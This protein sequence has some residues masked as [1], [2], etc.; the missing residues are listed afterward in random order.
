MIIPAAI[1]LVFYAG[2]CLAID[3]ARLRPMTDLVANVC[4]ALFSLMLLTTA[5]APPREFSKEASHVR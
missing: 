4:A 5:C 1:A 3:R 2:S